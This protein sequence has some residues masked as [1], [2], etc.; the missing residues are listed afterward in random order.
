[1][2]T[3]NTLQQAPAAMLQ[4]PL[5]DGPMRIALTRD[6]KYSIASEFFGDISPLFSYRPSG[7][8]NI[9]QGPR[10]RPVSKLP[11]HWQR[12]ALFLHTAQQSQPFR[13]CDKLS[14]VHVAAGKRIS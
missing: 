2:E 10:F 7:Y 3:G 9:L 6:V 13:N 1:M 8:Q 12:I 11:R 5:T 14:H 4:T